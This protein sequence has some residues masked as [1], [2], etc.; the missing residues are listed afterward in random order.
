MVIQS[1]DVSI[2]QSGPSLNPSNPSSTCNPLIIYSILVEENRI[3][4]HPTR[5]LFPSET[6]NLDPVSRSTQLVTGR[7]GFN[8]YLSE[9]LSGWLTT[10][11]EGFDAIAYGL[12]DK[13]ARAPGKVARKSGEIGEFE[14]WGL[15]NDRE[16][17][18]KKEM[19]EKTWPR[20]QSVMSQEQQ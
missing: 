7:W 13:S 11:Y 14:R 15:R 20:R 19:K 2:A 18:K 17:K 3:S 12:N 9:T 8:G 5:I 4:L 6:Q 10:Y 1:L 16:D